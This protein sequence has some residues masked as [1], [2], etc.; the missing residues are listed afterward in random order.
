M[1]LD[2]LH[3]GHIPNRAVRPFLILLSPPGCNHDLRVL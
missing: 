2:E 3:R 1:V